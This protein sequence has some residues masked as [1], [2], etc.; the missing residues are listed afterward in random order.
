MRPGQDK[1]KD[2]DA[3]AEHILKYPRIDQTLAHGE[4]KVSV[5]LESGLQVDVRLLD[6]EQFRRGAALLHRLEGAQRRSPWPRK[7]NGLDA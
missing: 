4:N 7:R 6:K 2:I 5:L 3:V 1:Q